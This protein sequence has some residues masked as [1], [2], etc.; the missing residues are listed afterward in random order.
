MTGKIKLT[1]IEN[2]SDVSIENKNIFMYNIFQGILLELKEQ[3]KL[4]RAD[5]KKAEGKYSK[6]QKSFF[7]EFISDISITHKPDI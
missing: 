5:Y 4:S 2:I 1:N 6:A 7:A 3:G